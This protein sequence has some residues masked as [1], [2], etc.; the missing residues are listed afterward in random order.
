MLWARA[1]QRRTA[2][3]FSVPRTSRRR[4][5]RLR[6][7]AVTSSAVAMRCRSGRPGVVAAHA[8][9]P[10]GD[11]GRI[12]GGRRAAVAAVIARAG[13]RSVDL[14]R[15]FRG[16]RRA[17]RP[18]SRERAA[19]RRSVAAASRG[20]SRGWTAPDGAAS[21]A[22]GSTATP[23]TRPWRC[24]RRS[25]GCRPVAG[26]HPRHLHHARLGVGGRGPRLGGLR[27]GLRARLRV[28]P[29]AAAPV[30]I[31]ASGRSWGPA[32]A[33]PPGR[34]Q[35]RVAVDEQ[36]LEQRP[37][38]DA[39]VR[40]RLVI[41][42]D[43]RTATGRRHAPR[44]AGPACGRCRRLR[45]SRSARA[46]SAAEDR[47]ADG[48]G[49]PQPTGSRR[50]AAR[51]RAPRRKPRPAA[52]DAR[53]APGRRGSAPAAQPAPAPHGRSRARPLASLARSL[54]AQ[55][56]RKARPPPTTRKI[57]A[58]RTIAERNPRGHHSLRAELPASDGQR[59]ELRSE[60]RVMRVPRER[61][62]GGRRACGTTNGGA[63]L[64][65]EDGTQSSCRAPDAFG[66]AT[67]HGDRPGRCCDG[68]S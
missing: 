5:P 54:P 57:N 65:A 24:R 14:R 56:I 12:P 6:A 26:R 40:Q 59:I 51:G 16:R 41:D 21:R 66:R 35:R 39:E 17:S 34:Q 63:V 53:P 1:C 4:R 45:S 42:P 36:S 58:I 48:P 7:W 27:P 47:L 68:C 25:G 52:P 8:A 3:A 49:R 60:R 10:F 23:T 9:A 55:P 67:A 18:E 11:G 15:A 28:G 30:A 13:R 29:G 44:R 31:A 50:R 38:A 33:A 19:T 37:M 62:S 64:A 20:G 46:P 32:R 61:R 43:A 2:F 22:G